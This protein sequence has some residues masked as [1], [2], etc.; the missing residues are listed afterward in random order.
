M[1]SIDMAG[2]RELCEILP[3]L[4][5]IFPDIATPGGRSS[6]LSPS[7]EI[8]SRRNRLDYLFHVL[9]K[10]LCSTV[11]LVFALDDMQWA[12]LLSIT[13]VATFFGTM[14][15]ISLGSNIGLDGGNGGILLL[16][17]YRDN[18]VDNDGFLMNQMKYLSQCMQVTFVSIGELSKESTNIM[19]SSMLYL[20]T[21]LT[22]S[23]ATIVHQKT[24]G[25]AMF[26]IE[27]L[28][29]I[30]T[31]HILQFSVKSR[32]WVWDDDVIDLISI[33]KGVAELL[34]EKLTMLPSSLIEVLKVASAF[35][36]QVEVSTL[37][38]LN[39]D[40]LAFRL[41][42]GHSL[43]LAVQEGF[44][45]KAG[46]VYAF[47][48]D[49]LQAAV[50]DLIPVSERKFF[51]KKI[52]TNLMMRWNSLDSNHIILAA[53]QMN[54][55]KD[56]FEISSEERVNIAGLQLLAGKHS[57]KSSC[58]ESARSYIESGISLLQENHWESNYSLSLELYEMS[59]LVSFIDGNG[60][61]DATLKRLQSILQHARTFE[62]T[63]NASVLLSKFMGSR[64]N[65]AEAINNC[66]GI[67]SNLGET[68]PNEIDSTI[69]SS[70]VA[71]TKQLL[72]NITK[73]QI[74]QYPVLND[75]SKL[76][77][78]KF[79]SL[80][81]LYAV[82][83]KPSLMPIV[84]NRMMKLSF[85]F[86]FC[87]DSL[88]GLAMAAY[89][90]VNFGNDIMAGYRVGKVAESLIE[91]SQSKQTLRNRL[92]TVWYGHSR[93]FVE[94]IQASR[95]KFIEL[96]NQSML[97]GD[98]ENAM[99]SRLFYCNIGLHIGEAASFLS[100]ECFKT[101]CHSHNS[102]PLFIIHIFPLGSNLDSVGRA[103]SIMIEQMVS[104]FCGLFCCAIF[105]TDDFINFC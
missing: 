64:G 95:E 47:S 11:R 62:D 2:I 54:L 77:A 52:G 25:N 71:E 22:S 51:H 18:E 14:D 66:L 100:V 57:M 83:H 58:F 31:N 59:A 76:N 60:N 43:P 9:M 48:H 88:L 44:M 78:M 53:D 75:P 67:L 80:L 91:E 40:P 102:H 90:I 79:M 6:R 103:H 37:K 92:V 84:S 82:A 39:K 12:D 87:D 21:R 36:S 74:S 56:E 68:F 101:H 19:L 61:A 7:G 16:G 27:F 86:G 13:V 17:S 46:P 24:C 49:S 34:S 104:L 26:V 3:N 81:M 85:N 4:E 93:M 30:I 96:Y 20:P 97:S 94:P 89:G 69:V 55:C 33:S 98:L 32:R 29:S 38:L 28:K 35:G 99:Y 63:L 105:P 23:L 45:E 42:L 65:Y 5:F 50:Y 15:Q 72:A 73:E 8:G 1:S 70:S 10:S 41:Q